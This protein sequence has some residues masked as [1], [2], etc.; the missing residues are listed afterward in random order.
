MNTV[1]NRDNSDCDHCNPTLVSV[2][3][4]ES[5]SFRLRDE[6]FRCYRRVEDKM[7]R[8]FL[9]HIGGTRLFSCANCDTILTNRAELISTRFTGATGRAFLF[10]KVVNLQH[11]EVQDRV[12]LTGRHM[13]RDVSC[14][15][16]NSKLGWMYEF[17]TEESQRYK[18]G[19]VILERALVRESEG[20]EHV[21][22][23]SS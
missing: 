8:I 17:A 16:C 7:G 2:F 9:D 5:L 6:A 12:M 20:F 13:V 19:R 10:N 21:S 15:N 18:E 14:K 11:S 22:S 4:L 3:P 1:T 23:D